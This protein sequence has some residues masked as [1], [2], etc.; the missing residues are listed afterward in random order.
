MTLAAPTCIGMSVTSDMI[1]KCCSALKWKEAAIYL[2]W[3]ALSAVLNAFYQPL[4]ALALATN[5]TNL[6]FRLSF[7][8]TV[9]HRIVL[10]SL[11]LYFYSLTGV[12]ASRGAVSVIHVDFFTTNR[13]VSG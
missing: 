8:E 9:F 12:I 11:G 13:A 3:L 10:V 1:I 6:V 7:M 2:Q 5:R 4:H